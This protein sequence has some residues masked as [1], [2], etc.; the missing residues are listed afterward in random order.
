MGR[1]IKKARMQQAKAQQAL[2]NE[3]VANSTIY[4]CKCGSEIF[5]QVYGMRRI[6]PLYTPDKQPR[7]VPVPTYRC[8]ACGSEVR[9]YA[10]EP[11]D[12]KENNESEERRTPA[13][14]HVPVD[15][16]DGQ[17]PGRR[18]DSDN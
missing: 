4:K 13:E 2:A 6:S 1:D 3:A 12:I 9:D 11:E 5:I 15:N 14:E 8:M 7:F 18:S 17:E 16:P 10:N